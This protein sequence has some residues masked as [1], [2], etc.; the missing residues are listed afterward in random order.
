MVKILNQYIKTYVS[1]SFKRFYLGVLSEMQEEFDYEIVDEFLQHFGMM[2]DSLEGV[3][4]SLKQQER[5][6]NGIN[7]IFRVAHNLKSASSYLKIEPLQKL[8]ELVEETISVARELDGPASDEFVDWLLL[9]SDQLNA[10]YSDISEDGE[11]EHINK[12]I[13]KIP[14]DMEKK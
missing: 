9:V 6:K 1:L 5:Y 8:C 13:I 11:L 12:Q 2:L 4:V 10:W 14:L 7:E 3:I